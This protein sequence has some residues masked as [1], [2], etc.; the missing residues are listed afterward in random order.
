[1]PFTTDIVA[2]PIAQDG[3]GAR[4]QFIG[5]EPWND[6]GKLMIEVLS[7]PE[8]AAYLANAAAELG[9]HFAILHDASGRKWRILEAQGSRKAVEA[10]AATAEKVNIRRAA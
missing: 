10:L 4:Y 3:L 1:M 8:K 6:T 9:L 7:K 5:D 2:E